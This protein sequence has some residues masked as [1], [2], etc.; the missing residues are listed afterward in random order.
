MVHLRD[1]GGTLISVF[2]VNPTEQ[3]IKRGCEVV[4]VSYDAAKR[5]YTVAP[6]R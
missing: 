5:H 6:M 1:Q 3:T 4:L 2:A